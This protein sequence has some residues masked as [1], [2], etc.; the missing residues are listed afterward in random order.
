MSTPADSAGEPVAPWWHTLLV[1]APIAIGSVA[2]WSQNGL[3]NANIPGMS[4]KL[5]GYFIVPVGEWFVVHLIWLALR[6]GGLS[7]ATLV[8]GCWQTPGAFFKDLGLAFGFI[9]VTI[10]LVGF[11]GHRMER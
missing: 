3:L 10:P 6:R 5:S 7:F 1:P 11:L 9:V 2:S 8:A 4:S